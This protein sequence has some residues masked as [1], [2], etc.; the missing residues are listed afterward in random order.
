MMR[1]VQETKTYLFTDKQ[2]RYLIAQINQVSLFWIVMGLSCEKIDEL[3]RKLSSE[4]PDSDS[5]MPRL[6]TTKASYCADTLL[7]MQ[8]DRLAT[9]IHQIVC[10]AVDG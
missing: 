4:D 7:G 1:I 9:A 10:E 2:L 3:Y 6:S 8:T 5:V